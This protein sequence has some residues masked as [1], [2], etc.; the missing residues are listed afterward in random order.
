M[1][2]LESIV[3]R[4]VVD[5]KLVKRVIAAIASGVENANKVDYES[6]YDF[7]LNRVEKGQILDHLRKHQKGLLHRVSLF[8]TEGIDGLPATLI[9]I[10]KK[11]K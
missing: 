8:P 3:E 9:I 10:K 2:S 5:E 7:S 4:R 6:I 11:G 1:K